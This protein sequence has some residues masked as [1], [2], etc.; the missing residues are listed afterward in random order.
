MDPDRGID[1]GDR[2]SERWEVMAIQVEVKRR[3]FTIEEYHRMAEAGILH[4]DDRV[5]VIEGE[6]VHMTP[7]GRHHAACVA[8]LNR[9]LL[10]AVGPRAVR[11]RRIRSPFPMKPSHSPTSS[12]SV[13]APIAIWKTMLALG[14]CSSSSRWRTPHSATIGT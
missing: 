1:E 7:I 6:I 5:E 11:G 13:L 9:L 12:C 8:E 3:R 10:S 4:E 2:K 14:T